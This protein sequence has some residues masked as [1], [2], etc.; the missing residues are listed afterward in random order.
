MTKQQLA[1]V[2]YLKKII[3]VSALTSELG[4]HRNTVE[5]VFLGMPPKLPRQQKLLT[6][7]LAKIVSN[8]ES[9]RARLN[10]DYSNL[11]LEH[12]ERFVISSKKLIADIIKLITIVEGRR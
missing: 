12:R 2:Q 1:D 9:I 5:R 11:S 6:R 8:F 10:Q 3:K 4:I 7:E